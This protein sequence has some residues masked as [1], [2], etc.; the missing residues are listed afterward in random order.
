MMSAPSVPSIPEMFNQSIKILSKPSVQTFEEYEN[1]GTLREALIYVA[2]GAAIAG[3]FGLSNGINGLITNVIVGVIGF[4]AFTYVAHAFGKTQGGTGT[5]DQVAYVFSL[6]WVPV[7]V[8]F[9]LLTLVLFVT[10]IGII[11]I[12]L[13]LIAALVVNV[14]LGWLAIQ[15]SMNI[16]DTSKA[17]LILIVAALATFVVNLITNRIFAG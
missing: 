7:T 1:K 12:P 11:L 15:S 5:L 14:Y 17:W 6:F 10:V 8:G 13:V 4:L 16:T 2:V 3:L 9:S